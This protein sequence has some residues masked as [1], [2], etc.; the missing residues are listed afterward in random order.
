[1]HRTALATN[2]RVGCAPHR[3]SHENPLGILVP[4]QQ[5]LPGNQD[6]KTT[7]L[8][9]VS[10]LLRA[11]RS[12]IELRLEDAWATVGQFEHEAAQLHTPI[13]P[14]F[15]ELAEVLTA[16]LQVFKSQHGPTLRSALIVIEKRFRSTAMTPALATTLRVGYWKV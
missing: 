14:R 12:I 10:L 8:A 13:A 16:V 2:A 3:G 11:W 9:P 7:H 15:R 1:M 6:P 5:M 4:R